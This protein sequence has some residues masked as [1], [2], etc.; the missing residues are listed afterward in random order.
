MSRRWFRAFLLLAIVLTLAAVS[1]SCGR[2][3]SIIDMQGAPVS[4]AYV[5]YHYEG[6]TFAP[7]E[8]LTYQA[9]PIAIL[10]SDVDGRVAVPGTVRMHWPFVQSAPGLVVDL[11]YAPQLHNGLAWVNRRVAVSRPQEFDVSA[12]LRTVRVADVSADPARWEG[13][14]GNLSSLLDR[15]TS[16]QMRGEAAPALTS[17]LIEQ[18]TREYAA[19]LDRYGETARE[20]PVMP[21]ALRTAS[22]Q[23]Q[24]EWRVMV[25]KDLAARPRWKDELERGFGTQLRTFNH[26]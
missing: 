3:L 6:T 26:R 17:E 22:D 10:K 25:D 15:L 13:T 9:S 11:I 16:Q 19:M 4:G 20:T 24:R 7:A 2:T 5:F 21:E 18:F 8:S 1:V 14:L 23:E 12:D